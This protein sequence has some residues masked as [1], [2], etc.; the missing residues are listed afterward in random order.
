M[1]N[2][3]P[4]RSGLAGASA[5]QRLVSQAA[6]A[7]A[8]TEARNAGRDGRG[9]PGNAGAVGRDRTG[10]SKATYALPTR[11]Q[12]LVRRMAEAEDVSQT[13]IVEA[14]IVALYNAWEA[15]RV[16]LEALKVPAKSL[17]ATWHLEVNDK[18][19]LA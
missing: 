1:K 19:F 12:E 14:A 17:K 10:A 16:D 13:D 4:R 3:T 5:V 9:R 15:G 11:R 18:F 7:Q 6:D 2:D 8:E